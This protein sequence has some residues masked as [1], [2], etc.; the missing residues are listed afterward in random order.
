MI[1]ATRT[2]AGCLGGGLGGENDG[3]SGGP[4]IL[5]VVFCLA[6]FDSFAL[7]ADTGRHLPLYFLTSC[8][9]LYSGT[10]LAERGARGTLRGWSVSDLPRS[11]LCAVFCRQKGPSSCRPRNRKK[12]SPSQTQRKQ[13]NQGPLLRSALQFGGEETSVAAA[14]WRNRTASIVRERRACL[15]GSHELLLPRSRTSLA[16]YFISGT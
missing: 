14:D 12:A 2:Y 4:P 9:R 13:A 15:P 16:T 8:S 1:R 6:F 11:F 5:V 10:S 7:I 3:G